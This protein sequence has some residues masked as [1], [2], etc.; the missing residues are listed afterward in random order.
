M[1]TECQKFWE[2]LSVFGAQGRVRTSFHLG[3]LASPYIWGT[4]SFYVTGPHV[5][6]QLLALMVMGSS[7]CHNV[8]GFG[9]W[10]QEFRP[11]WAL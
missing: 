5:K 10:M 9:E 11:V 1:A 3:I 7:E 4:F 2:K 6:W 8:F